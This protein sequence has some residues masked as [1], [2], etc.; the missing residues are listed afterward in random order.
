[1]SKLFSPRY[2]FDREEKDFL[3]LYLPNC[4]IIPDYYHIFKSSNWIKLFIF[5]H[6]K[7]RASNISRQNE[8]TVKILLLLYLLSSPY[9]YIHTRVVDVWNGSCVSRFH[10]KISA[11][12]L[13][14]RD[15][16]TRYK[17]V[18]VWRVA[19]ERSREDKRTRGLADYLN[20]NTML[21]RGALFPSR[22]F[23]NSICDPPA[24]GGGGGGRLSRV[25]VR[26]FIV[27]L[28]NLCASIMTTSCS[29]FVSPSLSPLRDFAPSSSSLAR[30]QLLVLFSIS[31]SW[32]FYLGRL[33][34][35]FRFPFFSILF[36]VFFLCRGFFRRERER[37][38]LLQISLLDSCEIWFMLSRTKDRVL[39]IM[40]RSRV[41]FWQNL[42]KL[43]F[44]WDFYITVNNRIIIFIIRI[45][46]RKKFGDEVLNFI[47]PGQSY[48]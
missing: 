25:Q 9:I 28:L 14:R 34:E 44:I 38:I 21:Y 16:R 19:A 41:I 23:Y 39:R 22:L 12:E 42:L 36:P 1:M 33:V 26:S 43:I 2:R 27:T 24:P 47:Q 15:K 4:S 8:T 5:P 45:F 30:H 18:C 20:A 11:R 31:W 40:D 35:I 10:G 6:W 37:E 48:Y 7:N 29:R 32:F 17:G 13:H 3:I 46:K